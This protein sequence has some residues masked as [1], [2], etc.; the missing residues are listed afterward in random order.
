MTKWHYANS[1]VSSELERLINLMDS[2]RLKQIEI[3][4]HAACGVAEADRESFLDESCTNDLDLRRE[5]ESLLGFDETPSDFID[6]PPES[7]AADMFVDREKQAGF[8]GKIIGHYKVIKQIGAGGMGEVYL[9]EDNKLDRK[10]ALKILPAEFAEDKDRMSRFVREAKSASALNHP[11]IITI[12]EINEYEGT[13][14]I[15]TEF[16]DGKTLNEY[17]KDNALDLREIVNIAIQIA[18]ALDEAHLAGL[19]HRDIKPENVMIRKNG[20]V[21]VLDFGLAKTS[22]GNPSLSGSSEDATKIQFQTQPGLIIG[23]PNYMSPEQ[24]R[25]KHLDHQTDIFS[26]GVVLY[27]ML[28][29]TSPFTGETVSDIIAEV[30]TKEPPPLTEIPA[31]LEEIVVK[32]LKKTLSDRYQ[33]AKNLLDDLRKAQK[34]LEFKDNIQ[35]HNLDTAEKAISLRIEGE[36]GSQS[37]FTRIPHQTDET[38]SGDRKFSTIDRI[39][40]QTSILLSSEHPVSNAPH[41][42]RFLSYFSGKAFPLAAFMVV[43]LATSGFLAYR[44][45]TAGAGIRS[46]AVIP[47]TNETGNANNEYVSDGMSESVINK[48]SQLPQLKV[49]ART[50]T[51]R[52]KGK[53]IDVGEIARSLGV[54]AIITGRITQQGDNLQISVEMI[55]VADYA[56]IWGETYNRKVSDEINVP[57]AIT[58]AVAERLEIK[59]SSAQER[60]MVKQITSNTQA[61]QLHLNGVFF[62]RKN[63]AENIRKAIEYQNQAIKL[64]PNFTRAYVELSI[65]FGNLVDIGAISPAEGLP[66]AR[67]AAEKALAL[68]DT[69]A[70]GY[71]NIARIRKYDFE[72][73]QAE[74]GFKR[75]IELNPNLAAAHTLYA[76]FLSQLGRFDEALSEIK[77]AQELDPL[78]TGLVGNEGSIYYLARRYD[79]AIAM[80]QIHVNAAPENPFA[81]LGLANALIAGGR[82]AEAIGAYE[83]SIKLEET[84]STLIFLGRAYA[85]TGRRDDAIDTLNK[86]KATEK[87]VSPAELAILYTALGDKEKAFDSLEKAYNEHDVQLTLLRVDPAYDPLRD[88]PR[89]KPML[90]RLNL[91][92]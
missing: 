56:H 80:K 89:F 60:Q 24:A 8:A 13:H 59:L 70:D 45:F 16:I 33:T 15:A 31:E 52:Y 2:A 81:H 84:T 72:W 47:F 44:Y 32:S 20:V 90:K 11:N 53:E 21:K 92:E 58:Q 66:Q 62:R 86:L 63:G 35:V 1:Q 68:D 50:S 30:L 82:S 65:N 6:K 61:Y 10:V 37:D 54:G 64:D 38:R 43:A 69:L 76:E 27:E 5:V 12:Y 42:S 3:I 40:V 79:E 23:T 67:A 4:Y 75:A 19:V 78:R 36:P 41:Q 73:T 28:S 83:T 74:I 17:R 85:L 91:P 39:E 26:F 71:N 7:L 18:S 46:I 22:V 49:I 25:G 34:R 9:A 29:V 77:L 55:R 14:F 48:L 57:E 51:F 87:Y 88:D